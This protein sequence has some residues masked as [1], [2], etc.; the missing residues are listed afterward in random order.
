MFYSILK[1]SDNFQHYFQQIF[2]TAAFR[3]KE[4]QEYYNILPSIDNQPRKNKMRCLTR[5]Q[6]FS[7]QDENKTTTK[8]QDAEK[9]IISLFMVNKIEK[10]K[11]SQLSGQDFA[12]PQETHIARYDK[13]VVAKYWNHINAPETV[14]KEIISNFINGRWTK[15]APIIV[16][17]LVAYYLLN[18]FIVVPLLCTEASTEST[19]VRL[20]LASKNKTCNTEL[21]KQLS[22]TGA[23]FSEI[24]T[25]LIGFFV[26]FS[27]RNWWEQVQSIPRLDGVCISLNSFLW[28]D[29]GWQ[30]LRRVKENAKVKGLCKTIIRYHL[31]SWTMCLSR[32]SP[33]MNQKFKDV[34]AYNIKHLLTKREYD[35]LKCVTGSD[36]WVEKWTMPLLWINK[37]TAD[38]G[39]ET[40]DSKFVQVTDFTELSNIFVRFRHNLETLNSFN[41]YQLPDS[42]FRVL[43]FATYTFC[44]IEIICG[45]NIVETRST[46]S[47]LLTFIFDIPIFEIIKYTLLFGWLKT[48]AELRNPFGDD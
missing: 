23:Q 42:C 21:I 18:I 28:V 38:I 45:Q 27:I 37:L 35:A 8:E 4:K 30:R 31:L 24:L 26:S 39:K 29:K 5:Q 6:C 44:F 20:V 16:I 10:V 7:R 13:E 32:I 46:L 48:A 36:C 14:F 25:F 9:S 34:K 22:T 19:T 41:E 40:N 12:L 17:Y 47:P 15:T 33:K 3:N 43:I 11:R 2:V 1:N